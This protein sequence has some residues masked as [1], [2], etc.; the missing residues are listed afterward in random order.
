MVQKLNA[1]LKAAV[2]VITNL[3]PL[4]LKTFDS[5]GK[6]IEDPTM[7]ALEVFCSCWFTFEVS[8]TDM[9]K[10]INQTENTC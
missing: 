9:Y 6:L 7:Q 4:L 3:S 2:D 1:S 10:H 8:F 5:D